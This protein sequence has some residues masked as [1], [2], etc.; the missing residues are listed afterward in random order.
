MS[1]EEEYTSKHRPASA[2]SSSSDITAQTIDKDTWIEQTFKAVRTRASTRFA[3]KAKRTSGKSLYKRLQSICK[4]SCC[5]RRSKKGSQQHVARLSEVDLSSTSLNLVIEQDDTTEKETRNLTPPA[6][7]DSFPPPSQ[8]VEVLIH[9][10]S[11][12]SEVLTNQDKDDLDKSETGGSRTESPQVETLVK[13]ILTEDEKDLDKAGGSTTQSPLHLYVLEKEQHKE[14]PT[15]SLSTMSPSSASSSRPTRK[16]LF[17]SMK[18][19]WKKRFGK[20]QRKKLDLS[21]ISLSLVMEQEETTEKEMRNLTP[22]ACTDVFP[23]QSQVDEVLISH[24]S[25]SSEALT[26]EDKEDLDK[27]EAGGSTTESPL[28]P[29]NL[30]KE[31]DK[32]EPTSS[33]STKLPSSASSSRL[34][35]KRFF[36]SMK[37]G[38]NKRFGKKQ[39]KKLAAN[40]LEDDIAEE[41]SVSPKSKHMPNLLKGQ[42]EQDEDFDLHQ[43]FTEPLEDSSA[44]NIEDRVMEIYLPPEGT[45]EDEEQSDEEAE[46]ADEEQ[47]PSSVLSPIIQ[48]FFHCLTEEQWREVSEGVYN[49]DVKEKLLDMC[50][51]ILRFISNSVIAFVL[52]IH[53]SAATSDTSDLKKPISSQHL[54][55]FFNCNLQSLVESSFTE[56]VCE[57]L[58]ADT[59]VRISPEFTEAMEAEVLHEVNSVLSVAKQASV[60]GGSCSTTAPPTSQMSK[61]RTS[62]KTLAGAITTMKSFLTGR[63]NAV[64]RR[65]VTQK[66][67]EPTV[68]RK[69]ETTTTTTTT[70][71][72]PH[73][74]TKRKQSLWPMWFSRQQRIQPVSLSL[75]DHVEDDDMNLPTT[76]GRTTEE[77]TRKGLWGFICNIFTKDKKTPDNKEEKKGKKK[78]KSWTKRLR[79]HF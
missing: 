34:T 15:S 62:E 17:K 47:L 77:K 65:I 6:C 8:V 72:T 36:K 10:S 41:K 21:S 55:E 45:S 66:D 14:E 58:G 5:R 20:K 35:R 39:H 48:R 43:L 67:L 4:T 13:S 78:K 70:T 63:A 25:Q 32:E 9:H 52:S 38:W 7:T 40:C 23:S 75:Q 46:S 12:K 79:L 31:R 59:P 24:S 60:D 22:P 74:N 69:E 27:T 44:E 56:A 54:M 26:T 3:R 1:Q 57:V 42:E 51:D 28:Y 2:A 64:R 71:T 53:Q 68:S 50:M 33:L 49:N 30:E 19:R 61:K 16:R 37:R 73:R 11:Q 18:R 29:D 76:S